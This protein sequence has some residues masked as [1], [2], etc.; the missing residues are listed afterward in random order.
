MTTANKEMQSERM[1]RRYRC[2]QS[3][4]PSRREKVKIVFFILI[5]IEMGF[6]K[7]IQTY[8]MIIFHKHV[9]NL[10]I[11]GREYFSLLLIANI[12]VCG[13]RV[14]NF[15]LV[16]W[17]GLLWLKIIKQSRHTFQFILYL[18]SELCL[19]MCCSNLYEY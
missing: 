19:D 18:N 7:H 1:H 4:R 2:G 17:I 9:G 8:P 10:V 15:S 11:N 14:Y 3:S 12:L 5:A 16:T 6:L 13:N